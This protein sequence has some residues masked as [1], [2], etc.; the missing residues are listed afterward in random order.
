MCS[1]AAVLRK[2]AAPDPRFAPF[3]L[4][5]LDI[6]RWQDD[7]IE[8]TAYGGYATS[9]GSTTAVREILAA[10]E[11]LGPMGSVAE[12][13]VTELARHA[14]AW[15]ARTRVQLT[16]TVTAL[17]RE[18][19]AVD[20]L[21]CCSVPH[22]SVPNTRAAG[23][24][25]GGIELEDQNGR[26]LRFGEFFFGQPALLTFFYTRC[27]NPRKCSATIE[28]VA[29]LQD[30]LRGARL[31]DRVRTA[32]LTYDPAYDQPPLL[33]AYGASR[34][35][36]FDD[37]HRLLRTVED[38]AAVGEALQLGVN[39][40]SSVVNRH[41]LEALVFHP[42][43]RIAEVIEQVTWATD[44]MLRRLSSLVGNGIRSR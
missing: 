29:K 3:L 36:Q 4:R 8:L 19:T 40:V 38:F 13:T 21:D 9:G 5:A 42:D 43:G 34:G 11:W 41:R 24:D 25:L 1:A 20:S 26:R 27:D 16:R 35:W 6:M 17:R 32:S 12:A 44:D 18:R 2:V 37:N 10:L 30:S 23:V 39:F 33:R 31:F 15:P 28:R 14:S 22:G 7:A